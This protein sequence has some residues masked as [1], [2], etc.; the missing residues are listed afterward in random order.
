MCGFEGAHTLEGVPGLDGC[1]DPDHTTAALQRV[2]QT[3]VHDALIAV[4]TFGALKLRV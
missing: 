4:A 1:T 2:V 3:V